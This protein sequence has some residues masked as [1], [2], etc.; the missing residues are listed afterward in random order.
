MRWPYPQSPRRQQR[1]H[2]G[3]RPPGGAAHRSLKAAV[4]AGPVFLYRPLDRPSQ[5]LLDVTRRAETRIVAFPHWPRR[6]T[7]AQKSPSRWE[8]LGQPS[9]SGCRNMGS[10]KC[11]CLCSAQ[12]ADSALMGRARSSAVFESCWL[13][14]LTSS[15]SASSTCATP[16]FP[17]PSRHSLCFYSSR[18]SLQ[19][20]DEFEERRCSP[21]RPAM[22]P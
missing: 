8:C 9:S 5:F 2:Q 14:I 7:I 22:I 15:A 4:E 20:S 16:R 3:Q 19:G 17:P 13:P 12:P 21:A 18:S 6:A 10:N 1:G 11:L